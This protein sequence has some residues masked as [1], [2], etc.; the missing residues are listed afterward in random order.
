MFFFVSALFAQT[1]ALGDLFRIPDFGSAPPEAPIFVLMADGSGSAGNSAGGI[2]AEK[3]TPLWVKDLRRGEIV[4]FGSLPLTIFW[5]STF[6]DLY[7]MATHNWSSRYAPWPFKG[8]GAVDMTRGELITMFSIAV[9][10]SVLIAV[11][12]HI[13]VRQKRRRKPAPVPRQIEK[14]ETGVL[15]PGF[16]TPVEAR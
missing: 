1:P 9:S 16:E 6:F 10:S 5:V 12:D 7:R 2:P 13:I 3:A 4:V 8:A 14:L 11:V 15:Q